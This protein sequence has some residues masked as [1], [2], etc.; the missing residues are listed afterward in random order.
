MSVLVSVTLGVGFLALTDSTLSSPEAG[1]DYTIGACEKG[2]ETRGNASS[3]GRFN[4]TAHNRSVVVSQNL[5]YV[6]CAVL[7][8][9]WSID[10]NQITVTE[11]NEGD[12]CRCICNYRVNATIGPLSSGKYT[13]TVYGVEYQNTA[14][15]LLAQEEI[16][17]AP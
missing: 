2:S 1:L 6:C 15:D 14:P 12:M 8:L 16:E 13:I 7:K 10:G 9:D 5:S 3:Y 4:F 11:T 17:V